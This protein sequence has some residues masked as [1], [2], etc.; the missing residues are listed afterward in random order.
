ML[1]FPQLHKGMR[2][3]S[4]RPCPAHVVV[5]SQARYPLSWIANAERKDIVLGLPLVDER[6]SPGKAGLHW[7]EAGAEEAVP[8]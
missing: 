1:S 6:L 5:D 4:V 8:F 2:P 7:L 3:G